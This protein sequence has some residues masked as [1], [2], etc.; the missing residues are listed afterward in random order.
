M[1]AQRADYD[2][3]LGSSHRNWPLHAGI[4]TALATVATVGVIEFFHSPAGR[5]H[6]EEGAIVED[7][8]AASW[9]IAA[10]LALVLTLRLPGT[11]AE[12][13]VIVYLLLAF[14][15]RELDFHSRFTNW[16]VLQAIKYTKT[17]IPWHER[18]IAAVLLLP[19]AAAAFFVTRWWRRIRADW[20]LGKQ[21]PRTLL[22]AGALLLGAR[23]ADKVT[24]HWLT[25]YPDS[26]QEWVWRAAEEGL[27]L[28]VA[29][30]IALLVAKTLVA[31]IFRTGPQVSTR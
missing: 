28:G 20:S 26:N 21:W 10:A 23:V 31:P 25:W 24:G 27:E 13:L 6:V 15:F 18:M 4:L 29:V 19:L 17:G 16:N 8:S 11:R 3:P 1:S 22:G 30:I 14:G 9:F 7:A 2:L 5:R 12:L